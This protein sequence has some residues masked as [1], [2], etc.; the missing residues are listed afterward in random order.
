M[1]IKKNLTW[2][3]A[4]SGGGAKGFA[5]IGVLKAL[6]EGGWPRPSMIAGTSMGAIVGGLYA[7]GMTPAELADYAIHRFRIGEVLD[8]FV[9]RM[10]GPVG[11]I[12]RAGQMLAALAARPGMDGGEKVLALLENL[13]GGKTFNELS[14]PFRCNAVDLVTG[15]EVIF[16]SGS[17]AR[18]MRASMSFPAFFEPLIEGGRCLVDGGILDNLPVSVLRAEGFKRVLAVEV[19]DF[20]PARWENLRSGPQILARSME[21]A[22]HAVRQ[23]NPCRPNLLIKAADDSSPFSFLRQ[24]ELIELGERAVKDSAQ[25]LSAFFSRGIKAFLARRVSG[26]NPRRPGEGR[27][28]TER[29]GRDSGGR[30]GE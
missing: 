17:V 26:I 11:K 29:P 30:P 27:P 3:L 7:C 18:A 28:G 21:T 24:R 8:S 9:F 15:Q 6:E 22:L 4:L 1:R 20:L 23:R 12:F 19:G 13:T 14:I 2:A 5:H 10:N 16:R 25:D